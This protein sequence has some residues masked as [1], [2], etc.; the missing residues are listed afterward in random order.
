MKWR[1]NKPLKGQLKADPGSR[2]RGGCG[3]LEMTV[4]GHGF[5]VSMVKYGGGSMTQ[6][7]PFYTFLCWHQLQLAGVTSE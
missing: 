6:T 2:T 3:L 7:R 4:G 5:H 1:G